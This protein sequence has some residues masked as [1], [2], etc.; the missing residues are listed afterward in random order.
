MSLAWEP[1]AAFLSR[2]FSLI[3]LVL[4]FDALWRGDLSDIG[5]SSG[6]PRWLG[7]P[8]GTPW[9]ARGRTR[10]GALSLAQ[11][12]E[13]STCASGPGNIRPS[14]PSV[15][16]TRYGGSPCGPRTSSTSP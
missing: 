15:H 9:G 5:G 6:E 13:W 12:T 4:F 14:C 16:R 2:R 1:L 8:D 11:G 7:T 10:R 3:D